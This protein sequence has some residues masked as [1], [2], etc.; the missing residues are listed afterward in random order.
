MFTGN[1][2]LAK[3][4]KGLAQ[5]RVQDDA[6]LP[7]EARSLLILINGKDTLEQYRNALS[8]SKVFESLGGIDQLVQLLFDLEYLCAKSQEQ[9]ET[10]EQLNSRAVNSAHSTALDHAAEYAEE[11]VLASDDTIDAP[12]P[13]LT[14]PPEVAEGEAAGR[15]PVVRLEDKRAEQAMASLREHQPEPAPRK[16]QPQVTHKS[17]SV[18]WQAVRAALAEAIERH[19]S[20]D[21]PWTWLFQLERCGSANDLLQLLDHFEKTTRKLPR[22]VARLA[23]AL[24][25]AS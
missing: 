7:R 25:A 11:I 9:P 2:I 17:P 10:G 12:L 5:M 19:P 22:G 20:L 1:E 3:T 16:R 23:A 4:E 13:Q 14:N 8:A 15:A 21:D 24:R 18:D 6:L